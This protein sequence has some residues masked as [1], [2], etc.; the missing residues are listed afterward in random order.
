M[1]CP[2]DQ[3]AQL[4]NWLK[5]YNQYV[6]SSSLINWVAIDQLVIDVVAGNYHGVLG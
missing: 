4:I 6:N 2:I 1:L 3:L 5:F